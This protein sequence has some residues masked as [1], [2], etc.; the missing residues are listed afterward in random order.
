MMNESVTFINPLP[1]PLLEYLT[2]GE[3]RREDSEKEYVEEYH[4][5][6]SKRGNRENR[7]C[8]THLDELRHEPRSTKYT[9]NNEA[10]DTECKKK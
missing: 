6:E 8:E 2:S 1:F 9:E 3:N 7:D 10:Y 4:S 5:D